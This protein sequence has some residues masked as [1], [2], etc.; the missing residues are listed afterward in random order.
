MKDD[1]LTIG[2]VKF[3]LLKTLQGE[4][5]GAFI[6][7]GR[8]TIHPINNPLSG[9]RIEFDCTEFE[10]TLTGRWWA[11]ANGQI[12]GKYQALK[13]AEKWEHL[14]QKCVDAIEKRWGVAN[15]IR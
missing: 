6:A 13:D 1:K 14:F 5:L 10:C 3:H 2:K 8:L 9:N 15:D 11:Y 4:G 12:F 7:Y